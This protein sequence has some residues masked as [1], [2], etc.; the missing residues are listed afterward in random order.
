M[1]AGGHLSHGVAQVV[2][3]LSDVAHHGAQV[4]RQLVQAQL[5]LPQQARGTGF[6]LFGQVT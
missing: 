6:D 2:D 5:H 3:L 4:D 1:V